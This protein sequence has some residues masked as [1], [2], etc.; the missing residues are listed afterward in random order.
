MDLNFI[1]T[2]HDWALG[3]PLGW[4]PPVPGSGSK[5]VTG[6][7]F[8]QDKVFSLDELAYTLWSGAL[9][10]DVDF[11]RCGDLDYVPPGIA[12]QTSATGQTASSAQIAAAAQRLHDAGLIWHFDPTDSNA[13]RMA[14]GFDV[15][16]QGI[17]I[18]NVDQ[19]DRYRIAHNDGSPA[20]D[21]DGVAYMIWLQWWSE[22]SIIKA[23]HAVA[24]ELGIRRLDVVGQ[25]IGTLTAGMRTGLI[26][27][28]RTHDL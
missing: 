22:P 21:L 24:D 2:T 23:A 19:A 15:A 9:I 16:V 20:L 26:Y 10:A 18:G 13:W 11:S 12:M 8:F 3:I 27:I 6:N 1:Q 28:T 4:V 5:A 14:E 7:V 17:P 25:A